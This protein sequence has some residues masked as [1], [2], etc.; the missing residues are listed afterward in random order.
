GAG[1]AGR[2]RRSGFSSCGGRGMSPEARRL[3]LIVGVGRSGTSLISG[4]L[5]GLGFHIP[6]PEVDADETNPRGF[7]EPAWVVQFHTGLMRRLRVSVFDARPAAW[8]ISGLAA[9]E[10]ATRDVLGKWLE[11]QLGAAAAV[12]VKHP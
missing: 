9:R 12:V 8:E 3:V 6:Q 7:G 5:S 2:A 11:E 4:I 10:E 1:V